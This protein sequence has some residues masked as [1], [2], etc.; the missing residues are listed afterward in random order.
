MRKLI[1]LGMGVVISAVI[2]LAAR[3]EDPPQ[4]CEHGQYWHAVAVG[5]WECRDSCPG[6]RIVFAPD[7]GY[8][9]ESTP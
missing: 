2:L 5:K 1:V 8:T 3:K 4:S 9:C 6:Q 7:G